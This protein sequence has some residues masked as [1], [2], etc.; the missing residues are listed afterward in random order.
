MSPIEKYACEEL[1]GAEISCLTIKGDPWF[2]GIEVASV[3]GYARPSDAISDHVPPNFKKKLCILLR[4]SKIGK[5]PNLDGVDVKTNWISEAGLYRLVFKSKLKS[6]QVF[7]DWVCAEVLPSIR[8]TGSYSTYHYSRNKAEL[9]ETASD[10]W[11]TVR[12]LA[13]GREDDLHYRIKDHI[14][15]EYPDAAIHAGIGEHLTTDH[16][17]MDAYLKGYTGGQPDITVIRK[18]PNGFQN[19]LAIELKNPN[20]KGVLD[21]DQNKYH[22]RLKDQCNIKTIVDHDYDTIIFAIRDHYR[23]VFA[24]AKHLA[25]TDKPKHY[26]FS[27]NPDPQYWCNKLKNKQC[28]INEC[29]KRRIPNSDIRIK[30][31]REIASILITYDTKS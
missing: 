26:N 7:T 9:G 2:C 25:I 29:T 5:S 16:A 15:K 20:G 11:K 8:K 10:R 24:R 18:L 17:R 12:Q 23:Q 3:L 30:T 19:V 13:V 27:K 1:G 31:N 14:E 22:K 6:A 21:D 4:S 28:L